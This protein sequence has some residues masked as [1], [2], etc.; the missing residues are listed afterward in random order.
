M[1]VVLMPEI[2]AVVRVPITV[3]DKALIWSD[4]MVEI[5]VESNPRA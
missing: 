5:W 2:W 3:L 4:M 1:S